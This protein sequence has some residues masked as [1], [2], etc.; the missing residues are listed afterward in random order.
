MY[1]SDARHSLVPHEFADMV[2]GIRAIET[3]TNSNVD[4]NDLTHVGHM[5]GI[6]EKSIVARRMLARGTVLTKEDLDFKKPGTGI[7]AAR[8]ETLVGRRLKRDKP[9]DEMIIAEDLE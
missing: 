6:F 1:G 8:W 4:K 7:S 5:K 3:M 2:R 9:A